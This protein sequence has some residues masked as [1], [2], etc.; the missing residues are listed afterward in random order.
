VFLSTLLIYNLDTALDLKQACRHQTSHQHS[1]PTSTVAR[2]LRAQWLAA[3]ALLT[4]GVGLYQGRPETALLVLTGASVGCLYAVPLGNRQRRLK[5]FPGSKSVVVGGA[6]AI[7]AVSVPLAEH[8]ASWS[9]TA[10]STLLWLAT[11]TVSN[12][13]LFDV[14]DFDQDSARGLKT[15]V[16]LLGVPRVRV[17]LVFL[18]SASFALLGSTV[19]SLATPSLW[20]WL[21]MVPLTLFLRPSSPRAVFAL[22]LDGAL[23]LPW[24]YTLSS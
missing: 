1:I 5:A 16:V 21:L 13:T 10:W 11:L 14:R 19:P 18:L 24:L 9:S 6:V 17:A 4:L 7:A 15:L 23:F 3:F 2:K 20:L 8:G 22:V 12:A